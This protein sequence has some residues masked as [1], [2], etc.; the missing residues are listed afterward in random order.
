MTWH[1]SSEVRQV[2]EF[3]SQQGLVRES[4][5]LNYKIGPQTT[6]LPAASPWLRQHHR[7]WRT[8]ALEGLEDLGQNEISYTASMAISEACL[9]EVRENCSISC[10]NFIFKA[11]SFPINRMS[12]KNHSEELNFGRILRLDSFETLFTE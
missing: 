8:K 1:F 7:N 10:K 11:H 6:H 12:P 4:S 3:L 5:P 9:Y 2:L